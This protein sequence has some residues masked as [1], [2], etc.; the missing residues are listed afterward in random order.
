[1]KKTRVASPSAWPQ[2][3]VA[4][5]AMPAP[6]VAP[7]RTMWGPSMAVAPRPWQR[8]SS[9]QMVAVAGVAWA[10][11]PEHGHMGAGSRMRGEEEDVKVHFGQGIPTLLRNAG[12]ARFCGGRTLL[13]YS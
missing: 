13:L 11:A 5:S 2:Q 9:P 4:A 3:E 1:M 6:R 12:L 8:P 10:V 7:M